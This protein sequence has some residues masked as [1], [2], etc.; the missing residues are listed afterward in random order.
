M[1]LGV[2]GGGCAVSDASDV[3]VSGRE[4]DEFRGGERS[5]LVLTPEL[6]ERFC[7]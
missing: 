7:G 3:N 1:M 6:A 4:F 5:R 2:D